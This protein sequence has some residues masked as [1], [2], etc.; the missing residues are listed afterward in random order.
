MKRIALLVMLI[1]VVLGTSAC[2]VLNPVAGSSDLTAS[3]VISATE[4][5]VAPELG[6]RVNAIH[7]SEGDTVAAG[8]VLFGLDDELLQAQRA[9]AQ[10]AVE[11]ASKS[12]DAANAQL[13]SAQAQ[14][15]L[16]LQQVRLQDTPSRAADW[17]TAPDA[18]FKLPSWYSGRAETLAAAEAEVTAARQALSVELANL[19]DELQAASNEDFV[20]A[21]KR[22]TG[23]QV[24]YAVAKLTQE[25]AKA[26][27][28]KATLETAA[29]ERLDAARSE[30]DAAQ[31]AYDRILSTSA[32]ESVLEAR[33]R[34][35]VARARLDN[36][37]DQ[38]TGLQTG[39]QSLQLAV[40]EAGVTQAQTAVSQAQANLAQA[41]AALGLIDLQ[42]EKCTVTAP[43]AGVITARDLELGELVA[44]GGTVLAISELTEVN[45]TVYLPEDRYGQVALGQDIN[46]TVDSFPGRTFTGRVQYIASE[47]EFTPRNVQTVDGRRATVYAVRIRVPNEQLELKPGMPADVTFDGR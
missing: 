6:G 32:A 39:E 1:A 26:A 19:D 4:I 47:A 30:L 29:Q 44:A 37:Q 41:Q 10:A 3:G 35:A 40:A 24:A 38:L 43:V 21:E 12:V 11:L 25:Q 31:L 8:D 45:L 34:V 36:A 13:E 9:Q 42:V 16:T 20:A 22:L 2:D 23:A 27:A 33:A 17:S 18:A 15:A 46:I 28:D 14:Y 7:V 5:R